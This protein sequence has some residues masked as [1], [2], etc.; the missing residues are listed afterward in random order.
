MQYKSA[1][2]ITASSLREQ[3]DYYKRFKKFDKGEVEK[4]T[5]KKKTVDDHIQQLQN[6]I[7]EL[8]ELVS[9]NNKRKYNKQK[10]VCVRSLGVGF[11]DDS[12]T[13]LPDRNVK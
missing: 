6:D 1:S 9:N 5:I 2:S 13:T 3:H 12:G 7:K 10:A 4:K 8:K 11:D